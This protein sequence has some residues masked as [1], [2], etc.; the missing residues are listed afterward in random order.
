MGAKA[1]NT[2]TKQSQKSTLGKLRGHLGTSRNESS[3]REHAQQKHQEVQVNE[4]QV[5][6]LRAGRTVTAEGSEVT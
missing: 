3:L 6:A 2:K 1:K 4:D 5:K